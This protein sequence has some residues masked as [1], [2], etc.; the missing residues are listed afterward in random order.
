[1]QQVTEIQH[2]V[3]KM[4]LKRFA[5]ERGSLNVLDVRD[6]RILKPRPYTSVCYSSFF[7][8]AET[9]KLDEISQHVEAFLNRVEN[10]IAQ[11]LPGIIKRIIGY[12][13]IESSD[14]YILSVLMSMLWLR[15]PKMRAQLNKLQGNMKKK[16]MGLG[17][18]IRVENYLHDTGT[19]LSDKE[20]EKLIDDLTKGNYE[21][22]FDNIQH[23]RFLTKEMGFLS[24]GFA[25]LFYEK[26]WK[27]Y[28]AK[29]NLRFM[30][31]DSPIVEWYKKPTHFLIG[32]SFFERNHYFALTPDILIELTA[33][34][35]SK[36]VKREALFSDKND[37][38]KIFNLLIADRANDFAYSSDRKTLDDLVNGLH[39][40]GIAEKTYV[41][42]FCNRNTVS[43]S[44]N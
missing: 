34:M 22:D 10:Y 29:G 12:E 31:S 17:A 16:I 24:S 8:G 43:S 35:G 38:V 33:P 23:L 32:R 21:L 2:F 14:R 42:T 1:M 7:Y 18:G 5:D 36:K 28:L 11:H 25:N 39:S 20:K 40:P 9:G 19:T 15:T 27:I 3:P 30:T 44:P 37:I 41:K 26:K 6:K 4:Y 13:Q